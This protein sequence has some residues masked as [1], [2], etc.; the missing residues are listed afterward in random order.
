MSDYKIKELIFSGVQAD[1][2]RVRQAAMAATVIITRGNFAT[3]WLRD[4]G[5]QGAI[6]LE[7]T[8]DKQDYA[9]D[10]IS[11]KIS[12][13]IPGSRD[14]RVLYVTPLHPFTIDIPGRQLAKLAE[15]VAQ[16]PGD[17]TLTTLSA[18]DMSITEGAVQALDGLKIL[19]NLFPVF[20]P[21]LPVVIH[22]AGI[23]L[24]DSN[25]PVSL[26][27]VYPLDSPAYL[28]EDALIGKWRNARI[29]DFGEI[30]IPIAAIYLPPLSSDA[31]LESFMQVIA[32][33]R[34]PDG[35]PWDR[36]QTHTSL[37]PYLLEET[38][39]ALEA[40]DTRNMDSLREELGDILL[41]IAL[42]AQIAVESGE[43]TIADVIQGINRKIVSRHPHVFGSVNVRDDRDVVQVWEK[44]KELERAENGIDQQKGLL[45][46]IPAIL[47]AL[48]QAQSIQDRAARVGFDWPEISPVIDKVMEELQEVRQAETALEREHELGDLLFAVVNL[49]RWY[50][51][52]AE[53]ALR[54]TNTKFRKR[55]AH[56]EASAKKAGRELQKMTL[57]EMDTLWE[58]SKGFDD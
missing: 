54:Y 23:N 47:P 45:D 38:Y 25:I 1:P 4:I 43:F 17:E 46:G 58:E 44:L 36:K 7:L 2:E 57:E 32:R 56:I 52:D 13:L 19:N 29:G 41:Q 8:M 37:R 48:S 15:F 49:V 24:L 42:H 27:Q 3:E 10:A 21:A 16:I 5:I 53:S 30:N 26:R 22:L 28:L 6:T 9:F 51:V 55:F 50:G 35:C 33:L 34:A 18:L 20:S 12:T 14:V 39:E 31:S 11:E 40:L